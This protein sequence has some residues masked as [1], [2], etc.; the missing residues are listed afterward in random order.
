MK[1]DI[2]KAL[3]SL[4]DSP[5][6]GTSYTRVDLTLELLKANGIKP[7]AEQLERNG[8]YVWCLALGHIHGP[9]LLTY[10]V[11]TRECYLRARR[12]IKALPQPERTLYGVKYPQKSASYEKARGLRKKKSV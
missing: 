12:K 9:K 10:G 8:G 1:W 2:D 11:N 6:P 4:E 7:T 5:T 3:R